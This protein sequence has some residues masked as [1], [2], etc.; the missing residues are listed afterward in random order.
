MYLEYYGKPTFLLIDQITSKHG[1]E[2]QL[3]RRQHQSLAQEMHT[4]KH[5]PSPQMNILF[6]IMDNIQQNI[7]IPEGRTVIPFYSAMTQIQ[8]ENLRSVLGITSAVSRRRCPSYRPWSS[9]YRPC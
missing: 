1:K 2:K 8:Q 4:N 6:D 5:T 7:D 9:A 3:N